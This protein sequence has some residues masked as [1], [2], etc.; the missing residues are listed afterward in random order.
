MPRQWDPFAVLNIVPRDSD[1]T[2]CVGTGEHARCGIDIS[3]EHIRTIRLKLYELADKEPRSESEDLDLS[4]LA[5]LCLCGAHQAQAGAVVE[6]WRAAIEYEERGLHLDR[7]MNEVRE[8][9]WELGMAN[10]DI[11]VTVRERDEADRRASRRISRS[12][13]S[14]GTGEREDAKVIIERVRQQHQR[15]IE[16]SGSPSHSPARSSFAG[17]EVMRGDRTVTADDMRARARAEETREAPTELRSREE[18]AEGAM[19]AAGAWQPHDRVRSIEV[20]YTRPGGRNRRVE[21]LDSPSHSPA[22]SSSARMGAMYVAVADDMTARVEQLRGVRT[23]LRLPRQERA[24][25]APA[26]EAGRNEEQ[27][28]AEDDLRGVERE[29]RD[30][31]SELR[32]ARSEHEPC[33]GKLAECEAA[34]ARVRDELEHERLV[35]AERED[36]LESVRDRLGHDRVAAAER[37]AASQAALE[38]AQEAA[39]RAENGESNGTVNGKLNGTVEKTEEKTERAKKGKKGIWGKVKG[40]FGGKKN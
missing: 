11:D 33:A 27:R 23:D 1:K 34:L 5:N 10:R 28:R 24:E 35:A 19:L 17:R 4:E 14:S 7:T 25:G 18:R 20:R 6:K 13:R 3:A 39:R 8:L 22:G 16:R 38:R 26:I 2:T 21:L 9:R 30:A 12:H 37:L 31:Q 15:R 29:L 40:L 36:S 32:N